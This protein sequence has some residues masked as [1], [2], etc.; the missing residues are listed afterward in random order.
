MSVVS[1]VVVSSSEACDAGSQGL[2]DRRDRYGTSH[3]ACAKVQN[4]IGA[5]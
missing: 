2:R 1:A 3:V 4:E 5:R